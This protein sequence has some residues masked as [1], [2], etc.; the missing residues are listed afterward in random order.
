MKS[1]SGFDE[2]GFRKVA[3]LVGSATL[4]F[5]SIAAGLSADLTITVTG[6]EV[7]DC[8]VPSAPAA[9]NAG[10]TVFAFVS[11]ANTVTVR[12][13]N[14]TAGAVDA[15]SATFNVVVLKPNA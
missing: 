4:D 11:A 5:G 9:L 6:A 3:A 1:L 10:L 8:V 7:G 13:V 12:L 2:K 15:A 14:N